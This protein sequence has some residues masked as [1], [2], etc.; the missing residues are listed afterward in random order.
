MAIQ[1]KISTETTIN[2]RKQQYCFEV[3]KH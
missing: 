1:T 2:F 3:D